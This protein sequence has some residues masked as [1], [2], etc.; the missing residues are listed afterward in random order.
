MKLFVVQCN[1]NEFSLLLPFF[2]PTQD[3]RR[4]GSATAAAAAS[5]L[6]ELQQCL[7]Y[8]DADPLQYP[9]YFHFLVSYDS[10][11]DNSCEY[12]SLSVKV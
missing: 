1:W 5:E 4:Y 2:F 11:R 10:L 6:R 8:P 7:H 12:T 3:E 9:L